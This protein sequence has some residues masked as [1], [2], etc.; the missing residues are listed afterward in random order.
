M[1]FGSLA[2]PFIAASRIIKYHHVG[3]AR[4]P[5]THT[6][7]RSRTLYGLYVTFPPHPFLVTNQKWSVMVPMHKWRPMR[8]LRS[9]V[10]FLAIK[11]TSGRFL[12]GEAESPPSSRHQ[13]WRA[14][15]QR[16][17][18]NKIEGRGK[19]RKKE[20]NL[21]QNSQLS[22]NAWQAKFEHCFCWS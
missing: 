16:L 15:L 6:H 18:E 21:H 17:A 4:H 12:L 11:R 7:T 10:A 14:G 5:H 2:S 19:E 20:K 13:V 9:P 8:P 1:V 22:K 3:R